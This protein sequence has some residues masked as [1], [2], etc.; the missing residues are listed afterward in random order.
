MPAPRPSYIRLYESGELFERIGALERVLKSCVLCPRRCMVDRTHG[1]KGLCRVGALPMVSSYA[2]HFG[3]EPPLTGFA[4]SGAI[5]MS[6]CNLNCIFC[7]NYDIS[8]LG[9]GFEVTLDELAAMMTDL[10]RMGCHN[11]NFVTP[12]HQSAQIVAALPRAIEKGFELPIVYN[13]GG[14]DS[15]ETIKLLEGVFDIYMPDMKYGDDDTAMLLSNSPDYVEASRA[16]LKEMHRQVGDLII[17]SNGIARRGLIVRHLVLPGGLAGTR[18]VMRFIAREISRDTYV[19]IMDQYRPCWKAEDDPAHPL[20][21]RR[22]TPGEFE[23]AVS[24]ARE[25]GLRRIAGVT[26]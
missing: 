7:Q 9:K 13:T 25:E 10:Q 18:E 15:V 11:V 6:F 23:E 24:I 21:G 4:G 3:E 19:N 22:I 14:Y 17:D 20:L 5:F 2:P 1:V 26:A 16:C 12:T 8:H